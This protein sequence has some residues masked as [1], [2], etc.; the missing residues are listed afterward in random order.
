MQAGGLPLMK[1][2]RVSEVKQPYNSRGEK[3][4]YYTQNKEESA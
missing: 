1:I 2:R 4:A 3:K